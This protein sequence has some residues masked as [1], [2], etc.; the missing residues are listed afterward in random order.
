VTSPRAGRRPASR[1][2]GVISA[3]QA[4]L[5]REERR[6]V[7]RRRAGLGVAAALALV[8]AVSV[9]VLLQGNASAAD[10]A[11][12]ERNSAPVPST[13][14]T[15]AALPVAQPQVQVKAARPSEPVKR[16][17]SIEGNSRSVNP[18]VRK[19]AAAKPATSKPK[20]QR[21]RIA[22]GPRG[23]E[24]SVVRA[25]AGRPIVLSVGR[26]EG[27][28]A[29]FLIPKLGV[30]EDNSEGSVTVNLGHVPAGRYRFSCGMDMVTGTLVVK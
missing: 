30:E 24:P 19:P 27:C 4:T 8:L 17:S 10:R 18:S 21:L 9:A 6:R 13:A 29:G 16:K 1:G 12:V 26:G 11:E 2:D 20:T 22:I 15:A 25:E 14:V 23:Y 28:A 5:D 3:L 7:G